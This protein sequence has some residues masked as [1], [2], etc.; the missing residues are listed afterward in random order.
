MQ[1]PDH[2]QRSA[3]ENGFTVSVDQYCAVEDVSGCNMECALRPRGHCRMMDCYIVTIDDEEKG[4]RAPNRKRT[5]EFHASELSGAW[6]ALAASIDASSSGIKRN[7]DVFKSAKEKILK[8]RAYQKKLAAEAAE[9][10]W[11]DRHAPSKHYGRV[12]IDQGSQVH[13]TGDTSE[14]GGCYG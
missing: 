7:R 8:E 3:R 14:A 11:G 4:Q 9:P 6:S 12:I 2:V 5:I 10:D 13:A 1:V